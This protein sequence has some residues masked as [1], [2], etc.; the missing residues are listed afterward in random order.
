M[1]HRWSHCNA[2]CVHEKFLSNIEETGIQ[3]EPLI[4]Q[5]R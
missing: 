1:A 5:L 4:N 3:K 2:K